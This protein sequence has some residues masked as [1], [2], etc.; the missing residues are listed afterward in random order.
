LTNEHL[1][2]KQQY[3]G[4]RIYDVLCAEGYTGSASGVRRYIGEL[5]QA[6]RQRPVYLPLEYDPGVDAQV[7]WGEAQFILRGQPSYW[8]SGCC[9]GR[10]A[11]PFGKPAIARHC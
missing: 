3:T 1:P 9:A 4:E 11:H 8:Y 5:R 10:N 2:R 7:D 6:T